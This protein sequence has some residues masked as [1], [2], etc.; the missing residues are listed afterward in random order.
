MLN[1][2]QDYACVYIDDTSVWSR[3]WKEHLFHLRNVFQVFREAGMTLKWKKC[4]FGKPK[5]KFVG[6]MVGT[7][8]IALV[9][10]KVEAIKLMPAP[11]T[12]NC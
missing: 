7:G 9:Q 3:T 5:V 10:S 11:T 1:N 12:K 8:E 4:D 2:H 6:H